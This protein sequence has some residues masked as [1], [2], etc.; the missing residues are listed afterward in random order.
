[1]NGNPKKFIRAYR[2]DMRFRAE[3]LL[4]VTLTVNIA[5]AVFE[6][7]CGYL[8]RSAWMGTLA[9][10]Y[11]MLSILRF[12][13]L[14]GRNKES[15]RDKW[16][17]VRLCGAVMLVLTIALAVIHWLTVYRGH[18][19]AYHSYIIY[20]IAAYTFYTAINAIRNVVIYRR[21]NDPILSAAKALNLAVAAIS[22]YSLQSA[23]ISAFGNDE[24]FRVTMGNLVGVGAFILITTISIGM[25]VKAS[26]ELRGRLPFGQ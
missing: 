26:R 16:R 20:A 7:V 18:V 25:I 3:M 13:I 2:K 10:Y 9:F 11:S 15:C 6:A 21:M 14:K 5:Y 1:M 23:M 19:I 4:Y 8:L 24:A 17:V 22:V 12:S